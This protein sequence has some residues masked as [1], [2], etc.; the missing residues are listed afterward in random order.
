MYL[1]SQHI[2]ETPFLVGTGFFEEMIA[3]LPSAWF[4]ERQKGAGSML[5]EGP[6]VEQGKLGDSKEAGGVEQLYS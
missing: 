5:G 4:G 6:C 1:H 3:D 2:F